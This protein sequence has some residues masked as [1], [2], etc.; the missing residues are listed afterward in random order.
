MRATLFVVAAFVSGIAPP[1]H[2]QQR[3]LADLL[4]TGQQVTLS[5]SES[6][7]T[8]APLG[9][10]A[11]RVYPPALKAATETTNEI[12]NH[13]SQRDPSNNA[14]RSRA[15]LE[16][17]MRRGV[18]DIEAM[19]ELGRRGGGFGGGLTGRVSPSYER[20]AFHEVTEIG[21]DFV[22]LKQGSSV[23]Y[24][25]LASLREIAIQDLT[26]E[27]AQAQANSQIASAHVMALS[28]M[29]AAYAL[30][31]GQLPT[32]TQGLAALLRP[33]MDLEDASGWRG[34]YFARPSIPDDPWGQPYA[35][36]PQ[37]DGAQVEVRANGAD[38]KPNTSDDITAVAAIL[39]AP[40]GG[41]GLGGGVPAA[42]ADP[43]GVPARP[44]IPAAPRAVVPLTVPSEPKPPMKE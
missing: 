31:M 10:Y 34:P 7:A 38:G 37:E 18:R 43:F 39:R 9:T 30:D 29:L 28:R 3:S 1:A 16:E 26:E 24:L 33:P 21:K 25:S 35:W 8:G 23:R 11:L 13:A 15:M 40:E 32:A 41:V 20:I 14:A 19:R 27:E 44:L 42:P 6:Q 2:A 36:T 22:A 17:A 4:K 5:G 12:L